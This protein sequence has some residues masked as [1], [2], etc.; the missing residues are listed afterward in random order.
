MACSLVSSVFSKWNMQTHCGSGTKMPVIYNDCGQIVF[1]ILWKRDLCSISAGFLSLKLTLKSNLLLLGHIHAGTSKTMVNRQRDCACGSVVI[2]ASGQ[3]HGACGKVS[4][5]T[6]IQCKQG[7]GCHASLVLPSKQTGHHP[8]WTHGIRGLVP[9]IDSLIPPS[10]SHK[11]LYWQAFL[12]PA[13]IQVT[14]IVKICVLSFGA[15]SGCAGWPS[16]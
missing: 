13:H 12:S 14:L 16:L 3:S 4:F 11:R 1:L 5:L 6:H 7:P 10:P 9:S 8:V 15:S 2:P